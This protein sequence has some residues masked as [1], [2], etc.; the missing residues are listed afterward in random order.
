MVIIDLW[1][2]R[3]IDWKVDG[4]DLMKDAEVYYQE[5]VNT[6]RWGRKN[7]KQDVVYAFKA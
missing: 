5:A 3:K 7:Q 1:S 2:M 6:H 4:S